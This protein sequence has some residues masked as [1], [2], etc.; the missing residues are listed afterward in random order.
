[1]IRLL[2]ARST[3]ELGESKDLFY[4]NEDYGFVRMEYLN[5]ENEKLIFELEKVE[6]SG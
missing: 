6:V 1:M 4:F 2:F 3:F 5:Y